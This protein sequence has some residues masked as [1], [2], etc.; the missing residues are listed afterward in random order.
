MDEAS[1]NLQKSNNLY[2]LNSS[3]FRNIGRGKL[4]NGEIF[5]KSPFK[6]FK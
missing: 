6:N 5:R 3:P 1:K 2:K 4:V